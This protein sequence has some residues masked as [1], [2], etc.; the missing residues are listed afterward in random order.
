MKYKKLK[1]QE[2]ENLKTLTDFEKKVLEVVKR[3][4]SGKVMTYAKVARAVGRPPQ[5]FP[6]A[7][8]SGA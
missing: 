8:T 2:F 4:S 1:I 3:I 7:G 6:A 5:E